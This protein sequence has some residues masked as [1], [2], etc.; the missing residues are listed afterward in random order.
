M[1]R[2][3]LATGHAHAFHRA[4]A[5]SALKRGYFTQEGLGNVDIIATGDD[6]LL[7]S[8]LME[9]TIHVG[10][11]RR[12]HS[13]LEENAKG[14]SLYIIAGI[15]NNLD[16]TLISTAEIKKIADLKGKKIGLVEKG[17]GRDATWIRLLLRREG[18]DPDRDVTYITNAGYGSLKI[19]GPRLRRGD[20]QAVF[21]SGHYK[22]PE[23]FAKVREAGFN[24][25]AERSETHPDGLPD[26]VV[27]TT[28]KFLEQ[29]PAVTIKILKGIIRGYRFARDPKNSAI[30]REL[31]QT[32]NWGKEGFGWGEFDEDLL[33]GMVS[34]ARILPVDGRI[35][36]SGL[37]E[38]IDEWKISGKLPENFRKEQVLR[39]EF[40]KKAVEELNNRYGPEGYE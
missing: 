16:Y 23:L 20:Y 15:L 8:R 22:R 29:F 21:L 19:Q 30:L 17:H 28:G 6:D 26:R 37:E 4:S 39:L 35:S 1:D 25:L 5:I 31:Y 36:I 18:L 7:I 9:G 24:I 34:S 33:N 11:D 12:P 2:I 38:I 10:L 27:A 32:Q 13:L 14:T 40:L 3:I